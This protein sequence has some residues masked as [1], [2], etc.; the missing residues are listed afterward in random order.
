MQLLAE[1]RN[2]FPVISS[3]YE[4][5]A[6]SEDSL[7]RYFK[8]YL[9]TF[10]I[11]F[12]M[13]I[14]LYAFA[15]LG[16]PCLIVFILY[17]RPNKLK[18]IFNSVKKQENTNL[19]VSTTDYNWWEAR[20]LLHFISIS[21]IWIWLYAFGVSMAGLISQN[22]ALNRDIM[23]I[24]RKEHESFNLLYGLTPL[25]FAQHIFTLIASPYIYTALMIG[26][27][28]LE[29]K[30]GLKSKEDVES[31]QTASTH[32][33]PIA[34]AEFSK[35]LIAIC[36][37]SLPIT[38]FAVHFTHI[39]IGFIHSPIHATSVGVFYSFVLLATVLL[40]KTLSSIY[41]ILFVQEVSTD[42]PV[43]KP[44]EESRTRQEQPE[45][46]GEEQPKGS[47]EEQ[48]KGSG[49]EQPK[50]SGEEQPK[51]SGEEQPGGSGEEQPGGSG[52][53]QPG[54]SGEE[55]PKG[56]GEEQPGG[57][58][59]EQPGGSGEEQPGGSGEEQP[60]GSGEEQ[61]GGS[62]E[63][64][65]GG[66]GEEQPG[67][68]GE[69]Q[70]GGSGEEQPGESGEEQPGA[71]GEEQPGGSV[72]EQPGGSGPVQ[73]SAGEAGCCKTESCCGEYT[74]EIIFFILYFISHSFLLGLFAYIASLYFLLPINRAIDIAPTQLNGFV[75]TLVFA[76][77]GYITFHLLKS[78]K[79]KK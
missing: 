58:G 45:G 35:R 7:R 49:E 34:S 19:P 44:P 2:L 5:K 72:E 14:V 48:P 28:E 11:L 25:I 23:K 30:Y 65:P 15:L 69:E 38:T 3:N 18:D 46:S 77:A 42:A 68:A 47:G 52:E 70:P 66:S 20:T 39:V 43:P 37:L 13:Q 54:G 8:N 31:P 53:E 79:K 63:E 67:R 62:G 32:T 59:E 22:Q 75:T 71:S 76:F 61:P 26:L 78:K 74:H 50:G 36:L 55:Q 21:S 33:E 9:H 27:K 16:S 24:H 56:S 57:S 10:R 17:G 40:F 6:E 64:Q 73:S 1:K 12:S 60:G 41:Y 29:K 4:P 51:G